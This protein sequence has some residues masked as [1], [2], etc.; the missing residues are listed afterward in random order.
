MK[1]FHFSLG[2][3]TDGPI[4]YC[5]RVYAETREEAVE[6]LRHELPE[7]HDLSIT[8]GPLGGEGVD[9]ITVYTNHA[10]ITVDDIDEEEDVVACKLCG[11]WV[12]ADTAH[13]HQDAWIGDE[14]CWDERLRSSE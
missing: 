12:P 1:N 11:E 14:C 8:S 5:A 13:L 4:G 6:L 3:S 10:Q 2:N 7:D 9:Y